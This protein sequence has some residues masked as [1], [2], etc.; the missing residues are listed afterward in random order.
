MINYIRHDEQFHGTIKL[1]TGEE[2]LGEIL[3]SEDPDTKQ[4]LIFVQNPAKT[5]IVELDEADGTG[6]RVGMGFMRW[7]N[8]SEED[9][10]VIDERSVISIAPM[11]KEAVSMYERWVK[12]EIHNEEEPE[13]GH[14]PINKN[15]GLIGTVDEARNLL[16]R[17]YKN[18]NN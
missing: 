16:E 2:I 4:D 8:F 6:Q 14:V 9:F 3:V 10:Y 7:M 11:S 1:I 13:K 12:K 5:K 15:M 18:S 17:L